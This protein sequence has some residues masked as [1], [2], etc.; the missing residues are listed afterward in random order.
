MSGGRYQKGMAFALSKIL[1]VLFN[2]GHLLLFA[3]LLGA[4]AL[5]APLPGL[6]SAGRWI[7][8]SVLLALG[9]LA[10]LPAGIWLAPLENRFPAP[11]G[12]PARV[13]GVIALGGALDVKRSHRRGSPELTEAAD[14]LA[15]LLELARRYPEA[16]LI[17]TGGNGSLLDNGTREADLVP[18][19]LTR[20]GVA[21]GR[22]ILERGSRNTHENAVLSKAMANPR[23]G[24]TWVL[25]TSAFHMPRAVGVFRR[26]G[27][28]VIPYPVDHQSLGRPDWTSAPDLAR[29]LAEVT[30]AAKEWIGLVAYRLFDWS[31]SLFPGPQ[32]AMASPTPVPKWPAAA[33]LPAGRVCGT[34]GQ[35]RLV[36]WGWGLG[37]CRRSRE[38]TPWLLG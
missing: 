18:D 25:V 7:V 34:R 11:D 6:R 29:G 10:V 4:V 22:L 37:E 35:S 1:W 3:G 30:L 32:S 15:A 38:G 2:P 28:P 19:L 23:P 16:R 31:D 21:P 13:D 12:L 33:A 17:F 9:L 14:R 8:A 27:W 36:T 20:I 24:E 5:F 26:S